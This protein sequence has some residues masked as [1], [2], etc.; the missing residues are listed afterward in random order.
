MDLRKRFIYYKDL[1]KY[2]IYKFTTNSF[3]KIQ[4]PMHQVLLQLNA[5]GLF[6]QGKITALEMF[7]Y[8]G[9]WHTMDYIEFVD[10]L[11][12]FEIDSEFSQL[13]K[14]NLKKYN[15]R[16]YCKDS[17]AYIKSTD[18]KYNLV[19]ADIPNDTVFYDDKGVP[20]FW[21]DIIRVADDNAVIITNILNGFYQ[22]GFIQL[23][24]K[25]INREIKD[26]FWVTRNEE[27]SYIVL[28][29]K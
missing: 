29:L 1:G 9:L 23:I 13:S 22:Q 28:C 24:T 19:V 27:V 16:F 20:L 5:K 8:H 26:I 15:V 12:I 3:H 25:Q 21:K 10:C 14:K 6:P 7:G 11:D 18:C 17:I 4:T 2:I